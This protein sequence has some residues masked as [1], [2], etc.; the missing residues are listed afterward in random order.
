[1]TPKNITIIVTTKSTITQTP[2]RTDVRITLRIITHILLCAV[3]SEPI[4]CNNPHNPPGKRSKQAPQ[5]V[6]AETMSARPYQVVVFGATGFTGRL[7]CEHLLADYPKG[8]R[9]AMAGRSKAKL[10]QV[11]QELA[12]LGFPNAHDIPVLLADT[13]DQAS[14]DAM[15]GKTQVVVSTAGPFT[16]FGTPL[17]D[18]AVRLKTHVRWCEPLWRGSCRMVEQLAKRLHFSRWQ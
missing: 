12:S 2:Q 1:M 5:T 3:L 6:Q 18:A 10:E 7:V 17:I 11:K 14:I 9:W 16:L 8:V 15:V 4:R 13:S